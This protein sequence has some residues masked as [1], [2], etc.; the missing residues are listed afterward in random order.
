[1]GSIAVMI[2]KV[3]EIVYNLILLSLILFKGYRPQKIT[4]CSKIHKI[5]LDRPERFIY[6]YMYNVYNLLSTN[7]KF[8]AKIKATIL[9]EINLFAAVSKRISGGSREFG[10]YLRK[11]S[12]NRRRFDFPPP[13]P[14]F[15][16]RGKCVIDPVTC[17]GK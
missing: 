16:K 10:A 7:I 15:L 11:V 8:H 17:C 12:E 9:S 6:E 3:V 2:T 5:M 14:L 1:M 13:C 4:V